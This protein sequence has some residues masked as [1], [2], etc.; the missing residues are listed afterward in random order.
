[1]QAV[2]IS[3]P[4]EIHLAP[5][6]PDEPAPE[7]IRVRP[8]VG[9]ICGTD[10]HILNGD[11]LGSYPVIPCHEFSAQVVECGPEV[12]HLATG[13]FVAV[14]PNIRCGKCSY[15]RHG[16]I[17]LCRQYRAVGVTQ[18]GGFAESV[19]L[20]AAQAHR[21]ERC[22]PAEAALAEPLACV[23]YGQSR[24]T[25]DPGSPVIIWGAGAIGMLHLQVCQRLY[26]A[27]VT[28]V[29]T[30]DRRLE[31][32]TARGAHHSVRADRHLKRS[33]QNIQ[34]D[35]WPIV[36]EAT[37]SVEALKHSFA[38]LAPGGQNLVFG[39][40]PR[41]SRMT[42]TPFE[43]FANDWTIVGSFTYRYE[44]ATAI[45]LI[46]SGH[47]NLR[48]LIARTASLTEVPDLLRSMAQGDVRGK[49]HIQITSEV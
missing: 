28:V 15:C 9:G 35:G 39:V 18:P 22:D 49:T 24:L 1:M 19:T 45:Q 48:S 26:G 4:G 11:F 33:L 34:T 25:I 44:F 40:Y 10:V 6:Q 36:I 29:D 21:F 30:D 7:H 41:D 13:D 12:E 3:K 31:Q 47:L 20:P 37:G 17:N 14:D 38:H 43:I 32:A 42:L 27:R 5:I 8:L 46:D 23:L 16:D 2:V